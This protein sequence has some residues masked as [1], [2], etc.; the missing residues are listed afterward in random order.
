MRGRKRRVNI[1]KEKGGME[2][3]GEDRIRKRRDGGRKQRKIR[4]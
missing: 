2:R 3:K 1:R 4:K